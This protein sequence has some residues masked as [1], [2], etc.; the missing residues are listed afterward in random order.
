MNAP[1]SSASSTTGC[2]IQNLRLKLLTYLNNHTVYSHPFKYLLANHRKLAY[3]FKNAVFK[4][5]G[6]MISDVKYFQSSTMGYKMT[7]SI[8]TT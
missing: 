5:I 1:F 6:L 7:F 3:R 8:L 2:T 4:M